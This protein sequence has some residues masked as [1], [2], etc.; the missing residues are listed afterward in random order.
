MD[1]V[2]WIG[3]VGVGLLLLGFVGNL[4][5]RLSRTSRTYHAINFL[6]AAI[7]GVSVWMAGLVPFVVL[8]VVWA[9]AALVALV[10]GARE[11]G[12]A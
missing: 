7:A 12:T 10:R 6:G 2:D 9:G 3:T 1:L 8:E 5:G 11:R 4:A